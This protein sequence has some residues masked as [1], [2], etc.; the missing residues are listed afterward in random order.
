MARI[1]V[2]AVHADGELRRLTLSERI[3]AENLDSEHYTTQL[4]ERV[5]WATADADVL[6]SPP[7]ADLDADPDDV[8]RTP[9]RT[10]SRGNRA[11]RRSGTRPLA[12]GATVTT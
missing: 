12:D 11:S 5:R 9:L 1:T 8:R 7:S 3:V 6:E 2:H 4:L 10:G